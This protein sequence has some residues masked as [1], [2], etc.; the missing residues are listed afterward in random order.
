MRADVG[1]SARWRRVCG[2]AQP[3][4]LSNRDL[5]AAGRSI[6]KGAQQGRFDFGYGL[7]DGV[8]VAGLV[9]DMDLEIPGRRARAADALRGRF[10]A[11]EKH[12]S[13]GFTRQVEVSIAHTDGAADDRLRD[14]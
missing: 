6:E 14:G 10:N 1:A 7:G 3:L 2:G 12:V 11:L 9:V 8:A 4:C 13:A 5:A